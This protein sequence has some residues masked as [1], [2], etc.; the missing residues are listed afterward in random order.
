[1]SPMAFGSTRSRS[2]LGSLNDFSWLAR[3]HVIA[4]RDDPLEIIA[5][6]LAEVP[7][8]PMNG[9]HPTDMTRRLFEVD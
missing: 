6:G 2:L 9:K 3:M 1:M 7:A 5:R 4:K 8:M